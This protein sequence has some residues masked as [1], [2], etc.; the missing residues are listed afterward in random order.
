MI[1]VATLRR[2]EAT[3]LVAGRL[4]NSKVTHNVDD[5]TEGIYSL[6]RNPARLATMRK[7]DFDRGN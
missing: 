4:A 2:L 3:Y 7:P 5:L 6:V 1:V